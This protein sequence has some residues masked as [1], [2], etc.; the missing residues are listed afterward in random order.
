MLDIKM[1]HTTEEE[2]KGTP[3]LSVHTSR[4]RV[5]ATELVK[6]RKTCQQQTLPIGGPGSSNRTPATQPLVESPPVSK[7]I[8]KFQK[9]E[10]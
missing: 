6:K 1:G 4:W 9:N 7:L 10:S 3:N 5:R 2:C 8:G